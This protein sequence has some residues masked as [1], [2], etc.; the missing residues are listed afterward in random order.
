MLFL[1]VY[2]MAAFNVRFHMEPWSKTVTMKNLSLGLGW[3]WTVAFHMELRG[4][5]CRRL[6]QLVPD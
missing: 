1:A 6:R 5:F 2:R 3:D 4:Q